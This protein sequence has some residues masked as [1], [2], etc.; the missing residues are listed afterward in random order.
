MSSYGEATMRGIVPRLVPGGLSAVVVIPLVVLLGHARGLPAQRELL[1]G[2]GAWLVSAA[3]AEVTLVDGASDEVVGSVRVPGAAPGDDL[4]VVQAGSSAYVVDDTAGTVARVDG[5]T[6]EV[7]GPVQFG[8]ERSSLSVH[9]GGT[10]AYVVDGERRLAMS[11]NPATLAVRQQLS[12]ASRPTPE[13][14]VVDSAGRLWVVDQG[15]LVWFDADG[16]HVRSEPDVTGMG[17][18]SVRGSAVLVDPARARVG[19]LA[20]DGSVRRWS[21]LAVHAGDAPRTLGSALRDRVFAVVP[22]TGMLVAS[23]IGD[24]DCGLTVKVGSPGDSFGDLAESG[25]FVLVPDRSTGRATVVDLTGR[26]AAADLPLARA[27][28]RLELIAKD[29]LVFYN[30]QDSAAAGVIRFDGGTWSVGSRLLKYGTAHGPGILTPS[31]RTGGPRAPATPKPTPAP[32]G[33]STPPTPS[34]T[35]SSPADPGTPGPDTGG[36]TVPRP[37]PTSTPPPTTGP[38]QPAPSGSH[39]KP[40]PSSQPP[41]SQPPSSQPPSSPTPPPNKPPTARL[42]AT[43][44]T[45][46]GLPFDAHFD[47]SASTDTD[48]H[49]IASYRFTSGAGQFDQT[50]PTPTFD[51]TYSTAMTDTVTVTVTDTAGAHAEATATIRAGIGTLDV[52]HPATI[53]SGQPFQVTL[54]YRNDTAAPIHNPH[55]YLY[56]ALPPN[57]SIGRCNPP[58]RLAD[59]TVTSPRPSDALQVWQTAG[60][61]ATDNCQLGI[62]NQQGE[63]YDFAPDGTLNWQLTITLT[64]PAGTPTVEWSTL[65]TDPA[66]FSGPQNAHEQGTLTVT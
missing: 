15:A 51:F 39:T 52:Q 43:P 32:T 45:P 28:N 58:L 11:V 17:L 19:A 34:P 41:S 57:T 3:R 54:T 42:S 16:K 55:F 59:A 46:G 12:L 47:A 50:R 35:G 29:G 2:G 56:L 13:Q 65:I 40:P 33:P 60:N 7:T 38:R 10:D 22:A 64:L 26:R 66:H 49:P 37:E 53:H 9:P 4:S 20:P 5:A 6:Y 21:C 18:V 14:S 1:R 23:G 44:T 8:D 27:G 31:P 63:T 62:T 36:P 30:D 48:A 24:T 25:D 61:G